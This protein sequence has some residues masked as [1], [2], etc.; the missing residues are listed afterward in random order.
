MCVKAHE[1]REVS[2]LIE[3]KQKEM[4]RVI[5]ILDCF[6]LFNI[7]IDYA[8]TVVPSPPHSTPSCPPPPSHIPP[9]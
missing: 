2:V 1:N 6:F 5:M 9:L 7:F 3:G 4:E 8:I